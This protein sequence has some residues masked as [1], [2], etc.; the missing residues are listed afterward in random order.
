MVEILDV[1]LP[2]ISLVSFSILTIPIFRVIR[3]TQHR[4]ALALAWFITA[5][6]VSGVA[7]ANLTLQYYSLASPPSALPF[8]NIPLADTPTPQFAS[9]FLIDGISVYMAI[10]FVSVSAVVLVYSVFYVDSS[11]R[12]S[13][14]YFA[15]MLLLTAALMGAVFAGDL[16]TLFIF[17]EAAAA[18]SS[19]LMI[20]K[21]DPVSLNS[22]LKYLVMIIIAS[23]F[24]VFGLSIV[25]SLTGSL[26]FWAVRD[27]L[28]VL[29]DKQ[30]LI[31]AFILIASGYA[32][33]AAIVPFHFWLPDAYSA[34]P[35]SSAA[36][37]SAL[38]DQ[39]SYYV[40]IRVLI[41]ILTP[42]GVLNWTFM[43]AVMA[44]LTMI[45]GNLF[46]LI[47]DNV[48]RLIANICVADVGYNLV[49]ITSVT[50]LGLTGNL[51]F[52]LMG[53][54]TTALSFMVVGVASRYG[55]KTLDE[56]S[57]LGKKMPFVSIALVIA[58]LSFAGVPP[59]GGFMA[60]YLV[61][62]AAIQADMSWLAVIGVLTSVVQVAY[63]LRLVNYMYAKEPKD[64]TVIREPK[65]MLLPIF[66]LVAAIIIL[67]F[68]PQIV[69]N[70]IDPVVNQLPLI[71]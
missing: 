70:L 5:F 10:M 48:K 29:A 26:N 14:R 45:V 15:I 8:L 51:Y 69:F 30:L 27:A 40:L 44:S 55:F 16:L 12:P 50:A 32:I 22:T 61:F 19:F 7:I 2:I 53:G 71:P 39:G 64:E 18:G 33:E 58:A 6:I 59:L 3:K 49:G 23:A 56:F 52:F 38:I 11:K 34:S 66:I 25:Y 41:F 1:A 36:F 20:Y 17:W 24:I 46:A 21:K 37:L 60:K 13:E 54:I 43:L 31:I 67:G 63:L 68:Y 62:T 57:G 28:M 65:R 9:G 35:S 47:Q 4:I 42:P